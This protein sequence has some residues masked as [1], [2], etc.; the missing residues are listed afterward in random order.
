MLDAGA[1]DLNPGEAPPQHGLDDSAPPQES[2]VLGGTDRRRLRK[3]TKARD[4]AYA[5]I[6]PLGT[7]AVQSAR[8]R[9]IREILRAN[10]ETAKAAHTHALQVMCANVGTLNQRVD[11]R[12]TM[13]CN[14]YEWDYADC[15]HESHL[16]KAVK[17][18]P[19]A[20]YCDKCS[21]WNTGGPL[22]SLRKP[23]VGQVCAYR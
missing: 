13:D 22:K 17:G 12:R 18:E 16:I 8:K 6:E 20:F 19:N 10:R 7:K 3:K 21:A 9:K 4:T 5:S 1:E 23:C 11:G 2:I 15:I 14:E